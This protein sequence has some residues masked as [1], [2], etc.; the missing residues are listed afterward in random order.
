MQRLEK[1]VNL[2]KK[3]ELDAILL[4]SEVNIQYA[5]LYPNLEGIVVVDKNG[6][7]ICFTDSRYI[8]DA[9]EKITKLGYNVIEPEGSYPTVSTI[10]EHFIKKGYKQIG[11]EDNRMSVKVFESYKT[12]DVIW[13]PLNG[14]L[15][16]LRESKEQEEV[17]WIK[18]AQKIAEKALEKILP[19]IKIG[20]Y[21][22]EL[23]SR[24]RYYMAKGGSES[25]CQG[26][27]LVSGKTTSLPHGI[28]L[29]KKL[30]SGGLLTIDFGAQYN[31]YQSDMTRT[32]AL[33]KISDEMKTVYNIVKEAQ[34]AG[35]DALAIGKTG[36][37][38]DFAARKVIEKAGYGEYF[39]H[40]LGHSIGLEVHENPRANKTC[41]S[42]LK[43]GTVIT[44]EPGIYLPG[45]FG[46]RIEDTL[47]LSPTGTINLTNFSKEL[48]EVG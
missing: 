33:G 39:G 14:Q 48:I 10:K 16:E 34:M 7:G 29:H 43:E 45:K 9:T 44:I 25:F 20:M 17:L 12:I 28:P 2:S 1:I 13:K 35:I 36:K 27:T 21:E 19:E 22:D 5:T 11:F 38:V 40:G 15:E 3:L 37:E 23:A 42:K 31:G 32:F 26:M 8:E 24:L 41:E 47:Y 18:E 4:T 46:V 6:E 30:E